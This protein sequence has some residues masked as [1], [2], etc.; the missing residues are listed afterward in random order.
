MA[1][2]KGS[3]RCRFRA[4]ILKHITIHI[5][6]FSG[7]RRIRCY[8]LDVRSCNVSQPFILRAIIQIMNLILIALFRGFIQVRYL[9]QLVR[10]GSRKPS[11]AVKTALDRAY[12]MPVRI[13]CSSSRRDAA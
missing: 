5:F 9:N 12:Q 8:I 3:R 11:I 13:I 2:V 7:H 4:F 6:K 10:H 1:A